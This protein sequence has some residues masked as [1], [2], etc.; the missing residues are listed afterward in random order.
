MY[1]KTDKGLSVTRDI[2]MDILDKVA[3]TMYALKAYPDK[4][5]IES[6]ASELVRKHPCLKEPGTGTGYGG[7]T[8]SIKYKLGNF[9]SKLRQA[10][11]NEV[12]VNE[13]RKRQREADG[14]EGTFSLKRGEV[15]YVPD[16]PE[17]QDDTLEDLR[18][19]LVDE[20]KKRSKN[21]TLIRQKMDLT[22]S[23]RRK[24]VVEVQA[25]VSEIQ[26]RWPALFSGKI[27]MSI[28]QF[29]VCSV[30]VSSAIR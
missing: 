19:A 27:N 10:G 5:E 11:C 25:M 20:M 13:K 26:D 24:E 18:L 28:L 29:L 2:K 17:N 30:Y 23:L 21:M 22:F 15:N 1:E 12:T 3:Q 14:E 8:T 4:S 6:V 16:H 9:R 7:W